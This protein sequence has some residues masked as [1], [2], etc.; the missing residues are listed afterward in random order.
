VEGSRVSGGDEGGRTW[1]MYFI[2]TNEN[3]CNYFRWGTGVRGEKVLV[4]LT[5][6]WC[7]AIQKCHSEFPCP[8][9]VY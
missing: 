7:K 1:L 3:F 6:V 8:I 4:N 2:Y 5:N 9:K